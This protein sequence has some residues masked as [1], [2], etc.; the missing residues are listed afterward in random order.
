MLP[1]RPS[2]T[3]TGANTKRRASMA[4]A[5]TGHNLERLVATCRESDP[6][7][8]IAARVTRFAHRTGK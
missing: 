5:E 4:R 7:T 3:R 8:N 1:W 2:V 6:F